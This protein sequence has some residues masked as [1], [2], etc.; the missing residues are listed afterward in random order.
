LGLA[1]KE[2]LPF[3]SPGAIEKD[4]EPVR[5]FQVN[6]FSQKWFADFY[7][8]NY[9]GFYLNRSWNPL[10]SKDIHPQRTGLELKNSGLSFTYI[11]NHAHYSMRA[12]YQFSEH[13][14][15][16]GGSVMLGLIMNRFKISNDDFIIRAED[17]LYFSAGRDARFMD[18]VTAAVVVGY[19][20]T[21]VHKNFFI[22]ATA[23]AGPS[24]HWLSYSSQQAHFDIDV[25]LYAAYFA[26]IGYSG[27]RSFMG[28]TFHAKE[29]KARMLET[30]V[31]NS[32]TTFRLVAGIRLK[33]RGFLEK[34]PK[35]II[36]RAKQKKI[37]GG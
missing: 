22:N 8:Q 3:P 9:S 26:A 28:I 32:L 34:R 36:N 33:E 17:Q 11:F 23:L 29:S 31:S 5:E 10:T 2:A 30:S 12:P 14:K 19:G 21:I 6:C 27:E 24:H 18:F 1:W 25:N 20:Y 4:L 7:A 13:Q 35:D 15:R 16:S 37:A